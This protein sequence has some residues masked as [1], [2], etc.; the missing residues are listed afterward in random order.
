MTVT[1]LDKGKGVWSIGLAG[2]KEPTVVKNTDSGKWKTKTVRFSQV[3][4]FDLRYVE[5][6]DTS[7]H[8]V[9][10]DRMD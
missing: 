7:F 3:G 8:L 10:V 9:E 2:A 5:G 4:E 6:A 1:Y